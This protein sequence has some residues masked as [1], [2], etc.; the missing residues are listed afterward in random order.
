MFAGLAV[1]FS[2][3]VLFN[4]GNKYSIA[5]M[6][7][8]WLGT[9]VLVGYLGR[10][11]FFHFSYHRGIWH[12]L[13]AAV[14]CGCLTAVVYS[15]LL[16]RN[17][18]VAWLAAGFLVVGY[19]T[20][21]VLDEIY[22]VDIMDAHIKASFGTAIK[23]F[24]YRHLVDSSVM[25]VAAVLAFLAAPP[26]KV[27]FENIS[28]HSLWTDLRQRMLPHE[29]W[30]DLDWRHLALTSSGTSGSTTETNAQ[31]TGS[32]TPASHAPKP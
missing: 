1:F 10:N 26:T 6:L 11:L 7:V 2:F 25:A 22:S 24:D 12:S 31:A 27:F 5:E 29:R 32:I 4:L 23:L 13:L 8:L 15:K 14:F 19:L 28:S 9:L 3:V 18:G 21:L 17:E 30:F 20:H 16:G